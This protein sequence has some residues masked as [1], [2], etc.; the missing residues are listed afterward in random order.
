MRTDI[1]QTIYL[2]DYT[3]PAWWIDTV[4]LHVA[5]HDGYAEVRAIVD[6]RCVPC[7]N[8]Q[9]QNKGI[10]LHTPELIARNA[11][12]MYQQAV[13]LKLM[14]QNNATQIT[15]AERAVIQRW[16]EAAAAAR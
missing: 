9:V 14:P 10:A 4:D 11:Q 16:F 3:P 6:Q 12:A 1:P 5:I 13:V 7:H 15:D 2:K 8:A